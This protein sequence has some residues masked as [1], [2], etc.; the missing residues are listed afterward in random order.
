ME[1]NKPAIIGQLIK[2]FFDRFYSVPLSVWSEISELGEI[3]YT[4]KEEVLKE[5]YAI[6]KYLYF[7]IKGSGGIIL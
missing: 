4:E 1:K 6:E 7:F 5:A 2:T 3:I